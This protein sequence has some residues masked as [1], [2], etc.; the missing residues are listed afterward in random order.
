MTNVFS[1]YKISFL[2]SKNSLFTIHILKWS[3]SM[4]HLIEQHSQTPNI[5]F[6]ILNLLLYYFRRQILKCSTSCNPSV[7]TTI[8]STETKVTKLSIE[9][10][11]KQNILWL[12]VSMHISLSMNELNRRND[13]LKNL[14][15]ESQRWRHFLKKAKQASIFQKLQKYNQLLITLI[16]TLKFDYI[17]ML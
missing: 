11:I 10:C 8:W 9:I 13:L 15:Y 3:L 17:F 14:F 6:L 2:L 7:M 12:N 16:H 5:N 4:Q 1:E